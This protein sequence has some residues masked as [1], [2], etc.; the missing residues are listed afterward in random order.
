MLASVCLA[1]ALVSGAAAQDARALFDSGVASFEAGRFEEALRSFEQAYATRPHPSVLVNIANCHLELG[2][3]VEAAGYFE[4]Y[5]REAGNTIDQARRSQVERELA[6]ARVAIAT[7]EVDAADGTVIQI[8]GRT[9]GATPLGRPIEVNPG[10]HAID[11]RFPSGGAQHEE[12]TFERGAA[13]RLTGTAT[14]EPI[15][16]PPPVDQTTAPM[17]HDVPPT[18]TPRDHETFGMGSRSDRVDD[19]GDE[20]EISPVV[21]VAGGASILCL[22]V[23]I[24]FGA[25]AL[26]QKDEFEG[27]AADIQSRTADDPMVATL[28]AEARAVDD[29]R[30]SNALTADLFFLGAAA[31]ATVAVVV[32]VTDGDDDDD[33]R[34][35]ATIAPTQD[36]AAIVA[37]GRF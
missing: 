15:E 20:D 23:G 9:A 4:R 28:Q 8:D 16:T 36:G 31:A 27:I 22:G 37:N 5:L 24:A 35:H 29:A 6:N 1:A 26:A 7:L 11:L 34:V 21:W 14:P 25:T 30:A 10:P 32:L 3:P 18:E 12:L 17:P 13:R 2:R 33:E 19:G